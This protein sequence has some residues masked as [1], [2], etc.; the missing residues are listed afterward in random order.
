MG[1]AN[2]IKIVELGMKDV[3]TRRFLFRIQ[4]AYTAC[5]AYLLRKLP[6]C[7]KNL[8]A[9][10]ALDPITRTHSLTA[11]HL[12]TLVDIIPAALT[13]AEREK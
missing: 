4:E 8:M 12:K 9:L 2:R 3:R 13:T 1:A 5:A 7:N 6:L 11:I 10:S